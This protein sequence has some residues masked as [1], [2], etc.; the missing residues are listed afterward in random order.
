MTLRRV[1]GLGLGLP[2]FV[3]LSIETPPIEI[4]ILP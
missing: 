1:T 2:R 3:P 4:E